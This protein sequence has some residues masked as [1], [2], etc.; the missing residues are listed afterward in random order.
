MTQRSSNHLGR[1]HD[2]EMAS[3]LPAASPVVRAEELDELLGRVRHHAALFVS[4]LPRPPRA[5]RV[6]AGAVSLDV[7]WA[8]EHGTVPG[9][10]EP[11]VALP[12]APVTGRVTAGRAG[13]QT[14]EP[15]AE[16]DPEVHY[17]TSPTVGVFYRAPEPGTAPFVSDGDT[18]VAGQQVGII[19]AMKL[20]IPIV[21][22]QAGRVVEVLKENGEPVEYGERLFA[23][24]VVGAGGRADQPCSA[25]C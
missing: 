11:A 8:Q 3:E 14:T 13:T 6:R 9:G 21:A 22:D 1:R 18:V 12:V 7:E 5:L 2:G 4:E 23:F 20:M 17:L 24:A 25:R 10:A 15:V 16:A 19:E